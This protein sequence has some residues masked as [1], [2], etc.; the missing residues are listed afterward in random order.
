MTRALGQEE[1]RS[2]DLLPAERVT[3]NDTVYG[4]LRELVISG[5]LAPGQS[6]STRTLAATL[7][8]SPMPVRSALQRLADDGAL[9]GRPNRTY[10][11]PTLS[12]RE[13]IE[14]LR[15]RLVLEVAAARQATPLLTTQAIDRLERINAEMYGPVPLDLG[16]FLLLNREFHFILYA[17]ADNS[18]QLRF[19]ETLWLQIGPLLRL[20][21]NE[22]EGRT[23]QE[24]HEEMARAA[25]LRDSNAM[26]EAISRDIEEAAVGILAWLHAQSEE[27]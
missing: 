5:R 10:R 23:G 22:T 25:R 14:I 11:I 20:V 2:L 6:L 16:T 7:G 13:F 3:L 12:P 18:R 26:A 4:D 24:P 19:I 17:A 27:R 1:L 21:S 8:V 9:E 15:L